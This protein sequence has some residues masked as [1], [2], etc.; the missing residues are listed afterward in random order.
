MSLKE[1]VSGKELLNIDLKYLR[2]VKDERELNLM[3]KAFKIA[4]QRF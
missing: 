1:A 2:M 4:D 3:W